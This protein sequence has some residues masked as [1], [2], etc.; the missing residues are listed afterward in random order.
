MSWNAHCVFITA[1]YD[2]WQRQRYWRTRAGEEIPKAHVAE[3]CFRM[4]VMEQGSGSYEIARG[5]TLWDW[6]QLLIVP[7][8]LALIGVAYTAGQQK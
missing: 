5:K 6:L 3:R 7:L 8:V 2:W 1:S 4:N